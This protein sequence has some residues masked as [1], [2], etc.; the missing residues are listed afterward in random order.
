MARAP[1]LPIPIFYCSLLLYSTRVLL[2]AIMLNETTTEE[3]TGF[4]VTFLS[5][6]VGAVSFAPSDY[7]YG[8]GA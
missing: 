7:A 3:K 4:Y 6:G 5:L 8:W 2:Y 1:W